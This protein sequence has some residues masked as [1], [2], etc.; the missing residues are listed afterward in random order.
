MAELDQAEDL[1]DRLLS[2][3][4]AREQAPAVLAEV[5][6]QRQR[7]FTLFVQPYD[8]V[9]RAISFVSCALIWSSLP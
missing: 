5:S 4:G 9:R 1:S 6:V 3:V 7:V 8:Q 2:A